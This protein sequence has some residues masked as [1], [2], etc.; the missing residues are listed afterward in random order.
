MKSV[1]KSFKSVC[2]HFA[3]NGNGV[4]RAKTLHYKTY[5]RPNAALVQP[6]CI[7]NQKGAMLVTQSAV[8][9]TWVKNLWV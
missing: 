3:L 8:C 1:M 7:P 2:N 9:H 6:R 4:F 5:K